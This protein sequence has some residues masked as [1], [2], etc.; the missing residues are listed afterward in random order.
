MFSYLQ[1]RVALFHCR[2]KKAERNSDIPQ[3][4]EWKWE[5]RTRRNS[6]QGVCLRTGIRNNLRAIDKSTSL[7]KRN[8]SQECFN[9]LSCAATINQRPGNQ[10]FGYLPALFEVRWKIVRYHINGRLFLM[11]F[12]TGARKKIHIIPRN[13]YMQY[14]LDFLIESA[15]RDAE[16]WLERR[17]SLRDWK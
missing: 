6:Q 5:K 15:A 3:K 4:G 13:S 9:P 14:R 12:L 16:S 7:R 10:S 17:G 2:P 8:D 1:K 11:N